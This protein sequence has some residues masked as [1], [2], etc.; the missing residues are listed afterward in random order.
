[1]KKCV[2]GRAL[3]RTRMGNDKATC[4]REE[5]ERRR[6]AERQAAYRARK[7]G[8]VP[9]RAG[10]AVEP[11]GPV[12]EQDQ[13]N[14]TAASPFRAPWGRVYEDFLVAWLDAWD[15]CAD[16]QAERE[17]WRRLLDEVSR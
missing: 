5:C 8:K 2:C 13:A 6:R 11:S 12:V 4:G 1:M 16:G 10:K 17:Q 7:S 15:F 9:S 14:P 3:A